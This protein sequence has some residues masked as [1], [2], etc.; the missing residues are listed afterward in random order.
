MLE[1]SRCDVPPTIS[2]SVISGLSYYLPSREVSLAEL[3]REQPDWDVQ[4]IAAKTGISSR[5]IAAETET[6]GDLAVA[7]AEKFFSTRPGARASIDY[8]ILCTQSPDYFLPTTACTIQH[9]LGLSTRCGAIDVNQGCSGFV[10]GLGLAKGLI[11]TGQA[12]SVLLLTAE[13]YSKYIHP[14]DRS[15]RTI[16]GDGAAATLIEAVGGGAPGI[17]VPAYATD[18]SG[19]AD[20]I[21]EGGAFR[22]RAIVQAGGTAPS[23]HL[24]MNGQAVM[25][26]TLREVPRIVEAALSR[27]NTGSAEID[28]FVM[29]QANAFMLETL[30]KKMAIEPERY[31][32]DIASIGNTVSSTIPI[33]LRQAVDAGRIRAGSK[34]LLAGFGVGLSSAA[35]V[36]EWSPAFTA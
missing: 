25:A 15:T 23:P 2:T 6:A 22:E 21:V 19:A 30:R 3:S 32:N 7:A 20:L 14:D 33:A 31:W 26:F 34:L 16:F 18:G 36:V 28:L 4:R 5:H 29:H 10:V 24:H 8:V 9:R 13:T 27:A 1:N 11:E 35:V 17:A 12:G